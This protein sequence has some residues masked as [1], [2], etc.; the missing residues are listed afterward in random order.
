ME[1]MVNM[2]SDTLGRTLEPK[3]SLAEN[4]IGNQRSRKP[5]V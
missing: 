3:M 5:K 2:D 1:A 4:S